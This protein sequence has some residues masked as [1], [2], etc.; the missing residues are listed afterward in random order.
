MKTKR[1]WLVAIKPC[2]KSC[3]WPSVWLGQQSFE[4][5]A[6]QGFTGAMAGIKAIRTVQSVPPPLFL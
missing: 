4:A 3:L 6:G 2:H 1:L 5:I